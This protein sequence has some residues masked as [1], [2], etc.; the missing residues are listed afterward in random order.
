MLLKL[1]VFILIPVVFGINRKDLV[2]YAVQQY[3]KVIKT[4]KT[5]VQYPSIA[6]PL[7]A[8]WGTT[9]PVNGQW[10][11]GFYPGLLWY[12]YNYTGSDQWKNLA[13][14]ATDGMFD[15]QFRTDTHDIGFM[16]TCSYGDGYDFTQ[17]SSY[18]KIIANAAHHLAQR[19]SRK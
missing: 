3:N 12:L 14:Q 1:W 17:N 10:T 13:I 19:F 4:V 9:G 15:D 11:A 2:D 18:P 8:T 5:G 6:S 16:I 7:S